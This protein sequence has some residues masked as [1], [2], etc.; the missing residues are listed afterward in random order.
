MSDPAGRTAAVAEP[1]AAVEAGD[2]EPA[3][4]LRGTWTDSDGA[5]DAIRAALILAPGTDRD[6]IAA[7]QAWIARDVTAALDEPAD[8]L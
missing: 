7:V 3:V 2:L 5:G 1:R 6:D 4:L 8:L